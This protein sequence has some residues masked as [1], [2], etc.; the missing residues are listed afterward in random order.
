MSDEPVAASAP[1]FEGIVSGLALAVML[2]VVLLEIVARDLFNRSFAW[3]DEASRYLMIWSV[4]FGSV[5][6][7]RAR[8]HLRVDLLLVRMPPALRR[9]ADLFAE[10]CVFAFSVALTFAG[11]RYVRDT[12]AM[13]FVSADSNLAIPIWI[14]QTVIPLT[15]LLSAV[16]AALNGLRLLRG[17]RR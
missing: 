17:A 5:A 8:T 11:F 13:G 14:V 10:L 2:A 4:Y 7:V 15:F 9:A 12:F 3:S 1:R 16:Y 6:A